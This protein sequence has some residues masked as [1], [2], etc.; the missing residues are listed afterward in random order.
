MGRECSSSRQPWASWYAEEMETKK[1]VSRSRT[2][3]VEVIGIGT[4]IFCQ[5]RKW[6]DTA[7]LPERG[8][9]TW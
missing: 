9:S 1:G 2:Y 4:E 7:L 5:H 8:E 6:K 3:V